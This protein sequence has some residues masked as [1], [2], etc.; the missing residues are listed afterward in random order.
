M[1]SNDYNVYGQ[2]GTKAIRYDSATGKYYDV[3]GNEVAIPAP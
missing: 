1:Q 2:H 3:D